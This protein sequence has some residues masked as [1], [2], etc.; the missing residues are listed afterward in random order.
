MFSVSPIEPF[1]CSVLFAQP[2]VDCCE[3]VRWCI[4]G[5]KEPFQLFKNLVRPVLVTGHRIGVP[6][7]TQHVSG[8]TPEP[9]LAALLYRRLILSFLRIVHSQAPVR[10]CKIGVDRKHLLVL[11][12]SPVIVLVG[13]VDPP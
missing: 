13:V 6:Q 7:S 3:G 8:S 5:S 1:E 12:D 2:C 9:C 11:P 4:G 10:K